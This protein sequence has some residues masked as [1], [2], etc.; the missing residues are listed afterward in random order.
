MLTPTY[1]LAAS[2]AP[3]VSTTAYLRVMQQLRVRWCCSG[4]DSSCSS[5]QASTPSYIHEHYLTSYNA[6]LAC[7][8]CTVTENVLLVALLLLTF[9]CMLSVVLFVQCLTGTEISQLDV[10]I[11]VNEHIASLDVSVYDVVVMQILEAQQHL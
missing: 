6:A 5:T 11:L 1:D 10:P 2:I 3:F 9:H 7:M 4:S 8:Q